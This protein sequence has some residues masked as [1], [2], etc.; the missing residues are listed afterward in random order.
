[1]TAALDSSHVH[2]VQSRHVQS[3][4]AVETKQRQCSHL[5]RG[6]TILHDQSLHICKR[7]PGSGADA[8]V[9]QAQGD[10]NEA[11]LEALAVLHQK[12][13]FLS[14]SALAQA[15]AP[16]GC[17]LSSAKPRHCGPT[18][19]T[20]QQSPNIDTWRTPMRTLQA[21]QRQT[22]RPERRMQAGSASRLSCRRHRLR[23]ARP[24]T[25]LFAPA[26]SRRRRTRT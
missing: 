12:L 26:R 3:L 25:V 17:G 15:C 24:Y 8:C 21:D 23:I 20:L 5:V 22:E 10:V 14:T 2:P 7:R 19:P 13:D 1:M 11:F 16:R 18:K 4:R 6:R 9:L